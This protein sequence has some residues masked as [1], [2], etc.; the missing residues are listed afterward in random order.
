MRGVDLHDNHAAFL[1][2]PTY[3][4]LWGGCNSTLSL[5]LAMNEYYW[6]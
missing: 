6:N 4:T 3:K 1:G 2:G 5:R